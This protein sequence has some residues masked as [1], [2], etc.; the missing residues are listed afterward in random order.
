MNFFLCVVGML[1]ILEGLPYFAFP[2]KIKIVILKIAQTP[3]QSLRTIGL[4]LMLSG[5]CLVYFGKKIG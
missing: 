5:L 3:D 4:I 2:E 1:M